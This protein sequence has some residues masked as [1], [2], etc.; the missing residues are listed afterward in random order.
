MQHR[1]GQARGIWL[2][3]LLAAGVQLAARAGAP[4]TVSVIEHGRVLEQIS[5]DV[6]SEAYRR[7]DTPLVFKEVPALR[8]L[9]E[10]VEGQVDG[11]LHRMD[12][13]ARRYPS[14]VQVKVPINWFEVVVL[15][16]SARF[17]PQG[18][19]SLRPYSVGVHRGILAIEQGTRGM[20][21]DPA[22]SNDLV[23][24]K[25]MAGRTDVAVM[26]DIEARELLLARQDSGVKILAPALARVPLYH[27][28]HKRNRMLA[29]R[30]EGVLKAMEAD[31]TIAAIRSRLLAR[32]GLP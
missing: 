8:A 22:P 1:V 19:D 5:R 11:E 4:V 28:L 10:S 17:V 23:L 9:A 26:P 15:T 21:I 18:W 25:L 20:R 7:I 14:L 30:L 32:A 6:L 27:Y 2:A 24:R 16:R 31:G 29:Q 12:G 13:L 3:L